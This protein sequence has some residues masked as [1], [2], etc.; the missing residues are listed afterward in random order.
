MTE[1]VSAAFLF[2]AALTPLRWTAARYAPFTFRVITLATFLALGL[3]A[4]KLALGA[5]TV[6]AAIVLVYGRVRAAPEMRA[7]AG[8]MLAA[9]VANLAAMFCADA[10][11]RALHLGYPI[12]VTP[13]ASMPVEAR[14]WLVVNV[15]AITAAVLDEA[16]GRL[17]LRKGPPD[18]EMERLLP[19]V[20]AY[21]IAGITVA[22]LQIAAHAAYDATSPLPWVV[23]LAWVFLLNAA[24]ARQLD[25]QRRIAELMEELAT[26]ERMA[27]VG[28]VAARV[29]HQTRHQL[30]LIGIT[31][32]RINKRVSSLSGEDARVVGEELEKLGEV[33]NELSGMLTSV[34]RQTASSASATS[35]SY[36][37]VVAAVARRLDA[38]AVSRGVV[39]D[40]RDL[41]ALR[42]A[43]PKSA[44][45]VSHAVFNVL[46]NALVAARA[47]VVV[48]AVERGDAR[49]IR[50]VDD[51]PGVPE[52]VMTRA[53]VPFVT[54]KAEGTGM[55]LA[56]ARAAVAEE[57]GTL[58]IA[59]R[60]GCTVEI[61][62][63]RR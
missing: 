51:G 47:K 8:A 53:A 52:S 5:V 41:E 60:D 43:S 2:V 63:P 19:A 44:E 10:V 17:V 48:E 34:L 61:V 36:A 58:A 23:A 42:G 62:V 22:P 49:V 54:T 15:F 11:V 4:A 7:R 25:R 9:G 38:L 28:E 40:V 21:L 37:D 59:N 33:Q 20:S 14:F 31:V 13:L 56:I 55:G 6:G 3:A 26:K 27:A 57:G 30:G 16:I 18:H 24:F 35:S 50:V 29:V 39:L 45:N 1:L 12:P 46:E 32:H